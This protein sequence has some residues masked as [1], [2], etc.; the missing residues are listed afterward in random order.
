MIKV[1]EEIIPINKKFSDKY[2]L[3]LAL[4]TLGNP[5]LKLQTINIVGTNGKTS[6][7]FFVSEGL[8]KKYKKIG[9]F[10][11]PA[12]LYHNE[13]IQ[14]NNEYISD[15]DLKEYLNKTQSV[16]SK[17]KLTFFEIWTLIMILYFVDQKVDI[18]VIE[19]GIGG[20]L[21]A[22]K[23]LS[24]QILVL[25][26]SVSFDHVEILGS[27][28]EL[29]LEQKMNIAKPGATILISHDNLKYKNIINK[30]AL[31]KNW[32]LIW[33]NLADDLV[34]YQRANKGLAIE[35]LKYF[36]IN[37]KT[38]SFTKPY[39]RFMI[40]KKNPWLIIDGAHN[41]DGIFN[42]IKTIQKQNIKP[43]ILYGSSLDK[44]HED[45]LNELH[46]N[47]EDVY[48]CNFDHFK[49]WNIQNIKYDKKIFNWEDFLMKNKDKNIVVCGSLY[50]VP[51][52]FKWFQLN[53]EE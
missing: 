18:A 7:S 24:N 6:T 45:I 25:L 10:T 32:K 49:S 20:K 23:N 40:L 8:Q 37:V 47:F 13:R 2:N 42:L 11:S 53:K 28:I 3:S 16:I 31:G 39:G 30:I 21:D 50:F 19:A 1:D 9:L 35:T 33:C 34:F 29:I 4:K 38:I 51:K 22:T 5:Q 36:G 46:K 15:A 14:I 26:T 17:Y 48:I 44:N 52:I 27:T 43:I 12:F 41:F